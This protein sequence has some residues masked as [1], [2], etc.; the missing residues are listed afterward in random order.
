MIR[1]AGVRDVLRYATPHGI[2][3]ARAP[4]SS[5]HIGPIMSSR[6]RG[7]PADLMEVF[8][9]APLFYWHMAD[10][11]VWSDGSALS[12]TT[13]A[14]STPQ[15]IM[16]G[17]ASWLRLWCKVV[18]GGVR[19]TALLDIS[20]DGG[21]TVHM[22][23]VT[24]A[25]SINLTGLGAGRTLACD[26]GT[27][28]LNDVYEQGAADI[29]DRGPG[30]YDIDQGLSVAASSP[31]IAD[32]VDGPNGARAIIG[33]QGRQWNRADFTITAPGTTPLFLTG[34]IR[35]EDD[36]SNDTIF[37]GS[38]TAGGATTSFRLFNNAGVFTMFNGTNRAPAV[39]A[40]ANVVGEWLRF[41]CY[42]SNSASDYLHVG[43]SGPAAVASSGNS[44]GASFRLGRNPNGS[45]A[46]AVSCA[47]ISGW[48]FLPDA[49]EID[50]AD[51]YYADV[52]GASV[53]TAA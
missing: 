5:A 53:L 17:G 52:Y 48:Q 1:R 32:G 7:T 26:A 12:K 15:L 14:G 23:N 43:G 24:T 4:R 37:S 13:G 50:D 41:Y 42:F 27:Y 20:F 25:A 29:A 28:I 6:Q 21:H 46:G 51:D 33:T 8:S 30:N 36:T 9:G 10:T 11:M 19:G 18:L 47:E 34:L 40:I 49:G 38:T 3:R 31:L 35:I 22:S 39:T 16:T 44:A 45:N 2:A